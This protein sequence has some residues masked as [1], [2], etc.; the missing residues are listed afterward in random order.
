M[1]IAVGQVWQETNTLNPITTT[2]RDFEAFGVLR[3]SDLV[4][5]MA[6]VN[7][8][9]GAIQAIR[10]W[11]EPVELVGLVRLP[12]W[13]GGT[14]TTPTFD[15]I[16]AEMLASLRDAL[17]VDG[18]ILA[19]HGAMSAEGHSDVE[20][21]LLAKVREVVGPEVPIVATLDLHA[22]VT[23]AMVRHADALVLYHTAPHIDVY[24]TGQRGA[25]LLRRI[26]FEDAQPEMAFCKIPAV[27]P[28][29]RAIT[30]AATGISAEMKRRLVE[31]ERDRCVLTAGIAT[32]QPWL[33]IPE[34][35]SAAI[36]VTDGK[37]ELA[38]SMSRDLAGKLWSRRQEYMT[39]LVSIEHAVARAHQHREGLV[40]LSDPADATTSGAPGDS[41]WILE[42]LLKYT[43]TRPVLVT[44]VSPELVEA[45]VS[46]GV[47]W[48][49]RGSVGGVRDSRFG[50]SIA[51]DG[52]VE[53]VFEGRFVLNG[54]LG[55][56]LSIDMGTCAVLRAGQVAVIV[57]SRSGPHFAPEL[58]QAA[59]FD[60][61]AAAVVVA[62]SPCGFRA[63]YEQK[64]A[65]IFS[66][67]APG[68]APPDFWNYRYEK[69]PRPLWPWDDFLWQPAIV[70]RSR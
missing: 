51:F 59:G 14:A 66:V 53:R 9:G 60:P 58:F 47:G 52:V 25:E 64:A 48:N 23:Q 20:G 8:L 62:K 55:K 5:K 35:G 61:F 26:L 40:V 33:D 17:P 65:E 45:C 46:H 38:E 3:G 30:Q 42:E 10:S 39:E 11:P 2:Q 50:K 49:Y 57:T 4:E 34:F 13:P 37:R 19:L 28:V 21:D 32:V 27:F 41:V 36:V 44:I 63:V 67:R 43:W 15:W 18:M 6:T 24:E 56:N 54:H 16:V 31:L 22:N 12:A 70:L 69:I 68:C 1:R 7:E 29:E